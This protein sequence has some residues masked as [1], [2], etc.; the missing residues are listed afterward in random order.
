M[1]IL[2]ETV[3]SLDEYKFIYQMV[4]THP[5]VVGVIIVALYFTIRGL[6]GRD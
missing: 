5:I 4:K 3:K 6:S 2:I 1:D